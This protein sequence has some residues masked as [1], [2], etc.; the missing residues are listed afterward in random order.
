MKAVDTNILVRYLTGDDP[1]QAKRATLVLSGGCYVPNTVL[2]ETAWLLSSRYGLDRSHL[3]ATLSDLLLLPDLTVSD[4][5]LVRWAV[6]RFAAGADIADM[7]HLISSRGADTF[8]SF[9]KRLAAQAGPSAPMPIEQ[10]A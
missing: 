4:A 6:E 7:L 8:I 9:D 10:P 3:A 2:L 5:D 1:E